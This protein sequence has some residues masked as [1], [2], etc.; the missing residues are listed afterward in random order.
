MD[1]HWRDVHRRVWQLVEHLWAANAAFGHGIEHAASVYASGMAITEREG[2]NP[3]VV[4][5][6]CYLMDSGLDLKNGRHN[7]I[8]R[9]LDIARSVIDQVPELEPVR[10]DIYLAIAHHEGDEPVPSSLPREALIVRDAD[11][12]DRLGIVGIQMTLRYGLWIKRPFCHPKDP[13]CLERSPEL[14]GYSLD[15]VRYSFRLAD[16]L[17]TELAK[18]IGVR[19]LVEQRAFFEWVDSFRARSTLPDYADAFTVLDQLDPKFSSPDPAL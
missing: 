18:A 3:L 10:D 9:S 12:L 17:S 8:E 11:T 1:P 5:A 15:Y 4:G 7:H 2:A 13:L 16:A 6:G 14:N 19:K